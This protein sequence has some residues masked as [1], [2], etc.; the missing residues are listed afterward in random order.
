MTIILII[1]SL[2]WDKVFNFRISTISSV[3]FA[4]CFELARR[5]LGFQLWLTAIPVVISIICVFLINK[6][7]FTPETLS[8]IG[9]GALL[10]SLLW[11]SATLSVDRFNYQTTKQNIIL[12]LFALIIILLTSRLTLIFSTSKNFFIVSVLINLFILRA[13]FVRLTLILICLIRIYLFIT[14]SLA[15]SLRLIL[16]SSMIIISKAPLGISPLMS[17]KN[18]SSSTKILFSMQICLGSPLN[19][20]K[21]SPKTKLL[22]KLH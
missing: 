14:T 6:R 7:K 8:N 12:L 10:I 5:I 20:I 2:I 17:F 9:A 18:S 21:C 19:N 1:F 13:S 16:N 22:Q 15:V 11:I 4:V 3:I